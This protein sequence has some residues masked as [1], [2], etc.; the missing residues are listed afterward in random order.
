MIRPGQPPSLSHASNPFDF[1]TEPDGRR[2]NQREQ[3]RLWSYAQLGLRQAESRWMI[4][5]NQRGRGRWAVG[6]GGVCNQPWLPSFTAQLNTSWSGNHSE[7]SSEMEA[8]WRSRTTKDNAALLCARL[9]ASSFGVL[10]ACKSHIL[11][12]IMRWKAFSALKTP[13]EAVYLTSSVW[14]NTVKCCIVQ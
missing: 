1:G 6:V 10:S 13:S 2:H 5:S 8:V 12:V 3:N 7:L 4:Y 11:N 14:D 9:H